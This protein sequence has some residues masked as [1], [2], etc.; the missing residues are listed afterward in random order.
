MECSDSGQANEMEAREFAG[1]PILKTARYRARQFVPEGRPLVPYR[2][3]FEIL[4][5][6]DEALGAAMIES[7][8]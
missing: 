5:R 1:R 8:S 7:G 3:D 6:L 2:L 4:G